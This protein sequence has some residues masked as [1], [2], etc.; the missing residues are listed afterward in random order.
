MNN[1]S[2]NTFLKE[3]AQKLFEMHGN[4]ISDLTIIMPTRR[5][6]SFFK[7]ELASLISDAPIW[8]PKFGSINNL[9]SEITTLVEADKIKLITILYRVYSQFHNESFDKFYYWGGVILSDFDTI[10]NYMVDAKTLYSNIEDIKEIEEKFD[11]LSEEQK[12]IILRFWGSFK[13]V[14]NYSSSQKEF[15]RIWNTLYSIYVKFKEELL[16]EKIGYGGMIYRMA[17]ESIKSTKDSSFFVDNRFAVIGFNA[18]SR[19]ESLLFDYLHEQCDAIFFWDYDNYYIGDSSQ[20]AGAFIKKNIARY[21]DG[22]GTFDHSNFIKNKN[23][24]IIDTPSEALSCK[25]CGE[26]LT[27]F[28]KQ[29]GALSRETAVVLT[30]ESLLVPLLHSL[31]SEIENLNITSGYPL[32]STSAYLLLDAIIKLHLTAQNREGRLMLYYKEFNRVVLNRYIDNFL[33]KDDK[34]RLEQVKSD[35]ISNTEA[36]IDALSVCFSDFTQLLFSIP[37]SIAGICDKFENIFK[38]VAVDST[39]QLSDQESEYINRALE[40][41]ILLRNSIKGS[42][43]IVTINI[44]Y[45]LLDRYFSTATVTFEGEPLIGMQVMGILES[46]NLDFKNLIVLSLSEDNYPS[47]KSLNSLIP[48]NLRRGYDLPTISNHEAMYSYYFYRLLQRAENVYL[49]YSSYSGESLSGEPSRYLHQLLIESPHKNNIIK[50]SIGL[51]VVSSNRERI[52]IKKDSAICE[53]LDKYLSGATTLSASSLYNYIECPLRFYFS[54]IQKIKQVEQIEQEVDAAQMGSI[55]HKTLE[56]VYGGLILSGSCT[57]KASLKSIVTSQAV[58]DYIEKAIVEELK[59]HK[60]QYSG[61]IQTKIAEIRVLVKSILDYD[62]NSNVEF[63]PLQLEERINGKFVFSQNRSVRFTGIIDRIDRFLDGGIRIVDY[64]SG[65]SSHKCKSLESVMLATG[66]DSCKPVFQMLLYG[67]LYKQQKG[68]SVQPSLYF[69]RDISSDDYSESIVIG[70]DAVLDFN[71]VEAE[72]V[73]LL[74]QTLTELF[75]SEI[76][77]YQTEKKG[78]CDYCLYKN[79]CDSD[80][81]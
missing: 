72:Y 39:A 3:C 30:N 73:E 50:R 25:Y 10:D 24:T 62:I 68:I 32:K 55:I 65:K 13:G 60:E 11:Y 46:R 45:A 28:A 8:Q 70:K 80:S 15:L 75:N 6:A 49:L 14:G 57:P 66:S 20:E 43:H 44:F 5:A 78:S 36:Y 54:S 47:L 9:M 76:P 37:N 63:Q 35:S 2:N 42:E 79:I 67:Y 81:Q 18:L 21:G 53:K 61:T 41:I 34:D 19:S 74:D 1:S 51:K 16:K 52:E 29:Q 31:P 27:N 69:A 71:S 7:L 23:I 77:F 4:D 40:A 59:L 38:R 26:L 56:L 64:K 22:N 12:E 58:D 33:T 17:A 48:S